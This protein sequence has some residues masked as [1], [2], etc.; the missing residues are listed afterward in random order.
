MSL[1]RKRGIVVFIVLVCA[2][3]AAVRFGAVSR[4]R[5]AIFLPTVTGTMTAA[6]VTDIGTND[7]P[8]VNVNP[9]DTLEYTVTL[10]NTAAPG[11]GNDAGNTIFTDTLGSN[12]TLVGGSIKASPIA[13][14]DAFPVTGNVRM[15][16]GAGTLLS[17]DIRPVTGNN[18]GLTITSLGGDSNGA[19]DLGVSAQGGQVTATGNLGD[20]AYNPPPGYEGTDS[21][22]YTI[23]DPDG[24]TGTGT[25][26]LTVSGMIWFVKND[27]PAC[28]TLA[29]GCGR[30]TNPFSSLAAFNTL[31]NGVGNN[32]AANDNI[33]LYT[34]VGNN[35]GTLTLLSGQKLIGQ[36]ASATLA[37]IAG[38]T[39][40]AGSDALPTTGGTNPTITAS[41]VNGIVLNTGNTIRGV[42]VGDTGTGTKIFSAGPFGTFTVGNNTTP[43]V[44]LSG[45]GKAL[46]LTNGTF[47][48]TSGFSS[49]AT[50]S[51]P[52]HGMQLV[53]VGGTVTFGST[54]VS[55]SANQG[56]FVN[57]SG[58]NLN[59]GNTTVGATGGSTECVR[60]E[61]NT[62]GTRT[63]GTLGLT[64]CAAQGITISGAGN[65]NVTGQ[66]TITNPGNVGILA[67]TLPITNTITFA[68]VTVN[69]SGSTGVSLSSNSGAVSFADLDIAPASGQ[70]AFIA[71]SCNGTTTSTSGTI[72]ATA[73]Q[74]I[75][76]S[77]SVLSMILDNVSA[78][79]GASSAVNLTSSSGSIVMNGGTI[80]GNTS[81]RAFLVNSGTV[82][83]T[84][85]GNISQ[86]N[87]TELIQITGGHNT[88]TVTFNTGTLSATNGT[89]LLFDNA[90]GIY[91]FNGPTTLNGGDAG[92]DI[93]TG[94]SGT[95]TFGSGVAITN[96]SGIAYREDT[97]TPT[98]TCSG[99]ISKTNNAVNAVSI[100]AKT[101]GTTTFSGAITAS[102]TTANAI[103]LTSNTGSTVAFGN[104][105]G[106]SAITT[107]SGNGFN[108]TGGGAVNITGNNYIVN[109]TSGIAYNATAG[110]VTATGTGNTLTSTT[111]TALNVVNTT[112]GASNLTFR[113]ISSNGATNGIVLNNTGSSGGLTVS[114]NG[115][116]CTSVGTCTGG[117]IQGG[118]TG[119]SLTTTRDVSID[120][121][122][123]TGTSNSGVS[124]V[125][126]TNFTFTNGATSSIGNSDADSSIAFNG[127][128]VG[129]SG[130]GRNLDGTLT[131]TGNTF[132]NSFLSGVDLQ[133]SN[134]TITNA[135]VSNNTII[136]PGTFGIN[137]VGVGDAATVANI[138]KATV[139]Q[140]NISGAGQGIQF[141]Y[142]NGSTTGTGAVMGIPGDANNIIAITNN[143]VSSLKLGGTQAIVVANGGGNSA[144]RNKTNFII[145]CNGRNTGGCTAP[146]STPLASSD[147]GTV[148]LVGNNGFSDMTG[149][150]DQNT[151][152]ATHTPLGGGGNGIAG[153]N[154]ASGGSGWTPDLTLT[155]TNNV[156]SGTDGNGILLVGRGTTHGIARMKIAN[157][158]IGAPVNAGGSTREGIRVDAGNASS[159]DDEVYLNIFSNTTAG[160][161]GA[162]GIGIR[163]QGAV[164]TTNDFGIFDAAGGPSLAPSP[165]NANITAFVSAL[166]PSSALGPLFTNEG[167]DIISGS[168]Y[169]RDTTQAP[170]R[171]SSGDGDDAAS[172]TAP[173]VSPKNWTNGNP[174]GIDEEIDIPILMGPDH[175]RPYPGPA[176]IRQEPKPTSQEVSA[177]NEKGFVLMPFESEVWK[178]GDG[179]TA[180]PETTQI[181]KNSPQTE[182]SSTVVAAES[183]GQG[184][185]NIETAENGGLKIENGDSQ[186]PVIADLETRRT[187]GQT[188]WEALAKVSEMISPTAYSQEL[189]PERVQ[190]G[191]VICVQGNGTTSGPCSGAGFTIPAGK[192]TTI[193]FR[194][195]I[196]NPTVPVN[197]FSVSNQ[198]TVS[199][200]GFTT[201][202]TD[203]D[204]GTAGVQPTVT[205]VVQP[206]TITKAFNPVITS[207]N[208]ASTLTLTIS[209]ANPAKAASQIAFVDTFPAG[210]VVASPLT[211]STTCVGGT[212]KNN[213]GGTLVAGDPGISLVSGTLP[214][215]PGPAQTCT[216]TVNVSSPMPGASYDNTTG[217]VSSFEGFTGAVSNTANLTIGFLTAA[218][219]AV[220]GRVLTPSGRGLTNAVVVITDSKGIAR[221]V[222]TGP[223]GTYRF[224]DIEVGQTYIISVNSRRFSFIPKVL[225][226][227][228]ELTDVDFTAEGF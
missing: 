144:S 189:R 218:R 112:I 161:N 56:I 220:S 223:L 93:T 27:A 222:K 98:V 1:I 108:I 19:F 60:L 164:S 169:L 121:M 183:F 11:A 146:T 119:V 37:S 196:S 31:N 34:G 192:S 96:P 170:L 97:S 163:K 134:G 26:T 160:S 209:N 126:V 103:S 25:V 3:I 172:D 21:F 211:A 45:T 210:L 171:P 50:T 186:S 156:I 184:L 177:N 15:S 91:N 111:G 44:T 8:T 130:S 204:P 221:R 193:K 180:T 202:Q 61:T 86:A 73:A 67:T 6:P 117:A 17:N 217:Q 104:T 182:V 5:S 65:V 78:S 145:Q 194:A 57:N 87:N 135:N 228:D 106:N 81:G 188:A 178:I 176:I 75:N 95:F 88:G 63:F 18:V 10:N 109:S 23:T 227:T 24:M 71:N 74:A 123:I 69:G 174:L 137:F 89:G 76:S 157:N 9:G 141:V 147:I 153:G 159:T 33:F 122:F 162:G 205:T 173:L 52:T 16:M 168:N 216:V 200:T 149:T 47:A 142:S 7:I 225:A 127:N 80:T 151:I 133:N 54:S 22:T 41:N 224:D 79:G 198:G 59:F 124:G 140:N 207:P 39:P 28:T 132:T 113:S 191:E 14:D 38:I 51:S 120:R 155:V 212:V 138:N 40:A 90:D 55:G 129:T 125:G 85:K 150:V 165:T 131:V 30:L 166:N 148:I 35:A 99:T 94:S 167:C 185:W 219:V 114:G 53:T 84:Y 102:T 190:V 107:T 36:G 158:T 115:G 226:V 42:T 64:S 105:T 152:L 83:S 110:T 58:V 13:L 201:F 70:T 179:R 118:A 214:A 199:G 136:N 66:T 101:G 2:V 116:T 77:S 206:P 100:N 62:G 197:T 143:T 187:V 203:G 46:D 20:F 181:A 48:A 82:S 49:V 68:D 29:A 92:I 43:D 72:T 195:A 4:A 32:P 12:L 128:P 213:T 175:W 215:A 139:N 154:G 208:A